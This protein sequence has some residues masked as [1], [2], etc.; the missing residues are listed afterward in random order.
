M[1]AFDAE[2]WRHD[3]EAAW[4]FVTVPGDVSDAVEVATA[5]RRRGFGS[6]RVR[7]TVGSTTWATS[8]FPDTRRRAFLLPL[9]KAVREGPYGVSVVLHTV[10]AP[11]VML[12]TAGAAARLSR[13]HAP[14]RDDVRGG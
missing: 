12:A 14:A 5:G 1:H 2:L 10:V 9:K 6:V 11:L 8:L 7:A 3:G 4:Y 13:R